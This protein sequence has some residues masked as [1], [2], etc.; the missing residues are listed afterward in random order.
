MDARGH[1]F[2]NVGA[3]TQLPIISSTPSVLTWTRFPKDR[4]QKYC[5]E[6]LEIFITCVL[7]MHIWSRI[8]VTGTISVKAQDK[9]ES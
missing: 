6:R 9:N 1:Y 4:L 2:Y 3:V 8:R 5:V 7:H